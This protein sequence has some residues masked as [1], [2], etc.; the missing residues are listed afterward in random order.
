MDLAW[1]V[2]LVSAGVGAYFG[3]Y[4]KTKG[5]NL[6]THEDIDKLSHDDYGTDQERNFRCR[7]E[8]PAAFW[9]P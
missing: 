6:A 3:G 7:M 4:L 5:E 1:V 8:P 2:P 9:R